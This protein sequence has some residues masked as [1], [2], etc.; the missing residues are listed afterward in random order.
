VLL[1][2]PSGATWRLRAAGAE[3]SLADSIYLGSGE[4]QPTRQ[5]VLSGV[6][7]TNGATV[8]WA[9]RREGRTPGDT[10]LA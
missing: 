5:I 7:S 8:R 4:M 2:L 3:L 1:K 9:L 10:T 6:T